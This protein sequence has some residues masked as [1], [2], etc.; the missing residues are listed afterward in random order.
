[1]MAAILKLLFAILIIAAVVFWIHALCERDGKKPCLPEDCE[2]CPF[3]HCK[4]KPINDERK[5]Y[6]D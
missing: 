3:P 2:S 4:E 1:M 6:N 5:I